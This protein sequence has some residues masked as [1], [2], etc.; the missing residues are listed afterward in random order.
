[1][2]SFTPTSLTLATADS[3]PPSTAGAEFAMPSS[4]T[5]QNAEVA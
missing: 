4:A 2:A 5:E 3:A 1:V